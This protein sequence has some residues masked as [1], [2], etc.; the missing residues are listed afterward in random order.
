[1]TR[2]PTRGKSKAANAEFRAHFVQSY[3]ALGE[4]AT[5]GYLQVRPDVSYQTAATEGYKL[6]KIPEIQKAIEKRRAEI[7]AQFALTTDRVYQELARI[8]YFNPKK[9]LDDKGKAI[10][11]HRLD[12]DTAAALSTVDITETTVQGKG[13][14]RV[15]TTR[16]VKGRPFN[17]N[18]ALGHA[19]KILRLYDRPPPPPPDL[20]GK[21][22]G[23]PKEQARR[24]AFMLAKG[25][26]QIKKERSPAPVRVKKKVTLEA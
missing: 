9:L 25:D 16:H 2:R 21:Q 23:D 18:T 26:A 13:K 12:D 15:V 4:N 17:K 7:R 22:L 24:L 5:Q 6:L 20:E 10:P 19:N 8:S 11:L 14:D 3:L 1:M